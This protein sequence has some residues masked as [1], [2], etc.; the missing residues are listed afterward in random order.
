MNRRIIRVPHETKEINTRRHTYISSLV[1]PEQTGQQDNLYESS[2]STTYKQTSRG[3]CSSF[4]PSQTISTTTAATN[5]L[6]VYHASTPSSAQRLHLIM[7]DNRDPSLQL[8]DNRKPVSTPR[9]PPN[10][11][12]PARCAG[13]RS[14]ADGTSRRG[15]RRG[16]R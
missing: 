13:G 7:H 1:Y 3:W 10:T 5:H 9:P 4:M 12:P 16:A 11:R 2:L 6:P 14:S 15:A 8:V